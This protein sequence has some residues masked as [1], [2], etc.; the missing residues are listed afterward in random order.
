MDLHEEHFV[1]KVA[2]KA[3]ILN[4][5][6][7]V[8]LVRDPRSPDVWELPGGRLNANEEPSAGLVREIKEELGI[9][10]IVTQPIQVEKFIQ[11]NEG[12][13]ALMIAYYASIIDPES[14]LKPDAKEVCEARFVPLEEAL[15]MNLFPE[16]RRTLES[17]HS[18]AQD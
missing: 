12:E 17:V 3:V 4:S 16:Y 1:G 2:Q 11:G 8:L 15:T 7:E 10:I 5:A 13:Y 6:Q 9:D 14:E 18:L